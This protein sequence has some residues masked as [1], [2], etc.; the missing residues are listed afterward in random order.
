MKQVVKSVRPYLSL[1]HDREGAV[2]A[3]RF[4]LIDNFASRDFKNQIGGRWTTQVREGSSVA[5]SYAEEEAVDHYGYALRVK[6]ALAPKSRAVV[7]TDLNGLDISRAR[8]LSLWFAYSAHE[9]ARI[10]VRL[11]AR[12]GRPRTVDIKRR[13]SAVSKNWQEVLIPVNAWSFID[14]NRLE[15]LEVIVESP[16]GEEGVFLLDHVSFFGP[17]DV[18]FESLKDNLLGF[19]RKVHVDQESI[20]GLSDDAL[21][22]RVAKDTWLY[23]DR[24]VDKR[25]H[26]PP[27]WIKLSEPKAIGDYTSPTNVG[28]YYL[29]VL[30]AHELG[31]ISRPEAVARIQ[32]SLGTIKKLPKWKGFLYNYYSSTNLGV[33][34]HFVSTVDNGWL[35]ASLM[36]VKGFFPQEMAARVERLLKGMDFYEFYDMGEGKFN[37]GYDDRAKKFSQSHYGLL[38]SEARVASFV[39]IAKGDIEPEH[40]FRLHRAPPENWTWQNQRPQGRLRTYR[41]IRV[42]EGYY[43]YR[44]RKFVPSW[45]GSLFEFLMPTLVM[46]EQRLAPRSL[47]INNRVAAEIHRDYALLEKRYPVWGISPCMVDRGAGGVYQEV[48]IKALGVKGYAEPALI[49]PYASILAL[50]ILP[51]DVVANLRRLL[52]LYP[53]YGQYGFYD[54]LSL[55]KPMVTKRYLTLDQGMILVSITNYLKKGIVRSKFHKLPEVRRV[56]SILTEEDFFE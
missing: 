7:R 12:H 20:L 29:A 18:F 25:T 31:F 47:A 56:E 27:D 44:S 52:D 24:I 43:R 40:W 28:L 46:D 37:L 41:D 32:R 30:C 15:A 42:F 3:R 4:K 2:K 49:A 39:G 35:A 14:F 21:L 48:G 8:S 5:L 36:T 22:R 1:R 26:L 55:R 34:T 53:V 17:E 13:L 33:T 9:S 45:G 50:E 16:D 10:K 51:E 19:P 23:F 38:A 6:Y 11:T 54:C